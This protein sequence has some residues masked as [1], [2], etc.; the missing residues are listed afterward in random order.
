MC[1]KFMYIPYNIYYFVCSNV[2]VLLIMIFILYKDIYKHINIFILYNDIDFMAMNIEAVSMTSLSHEN[3][4]LLSLLS[5][6]LTLT[7]K[8]PY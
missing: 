4:S 8:H 6:K 2:C 7:P 1:N 3:G 5:P